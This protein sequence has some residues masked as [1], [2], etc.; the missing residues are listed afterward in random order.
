[1]PTGA[2]T[3]GSGRHP[4]VAVLTLRNETKRN[5]VTERMARE[6]GAHAIA[7]NGDREI[8][9]VVVR[10]EG[11]L[12]FSA[13][14]D[15]RRVS[16]VTDPWMQ[17]N[18]ADRGLDY[19]GAL[20]DVRK[21]LV[22]AIDGFALG[23]GLELALACDTRIASPHA[24]FAASEIDWGWHSGSGVTQ[25]LPRIVGPGMAARMVLTG[26]RIEAEEAYRIRLIDE[27]APRDALDDRA[28]E[29]AGLIAERAPIA[30][31][32]AKHLL[33]LAQ[34]LGLAEGIAVENDLA[35]YCM[36]TDDSREAAEARRENRDPDFR[37][38]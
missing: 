32:S 17:R 11:R 36:T 30:V 24:T 8:R 20:L 31:Q 14:S 26:M 34:S 10:G 27:I 16:S 38:E 37:E 21:P 23:G 2:I 33:R 6:L 22:A 1:M 29:L 13:G 4:H 28:H 18:R 15:L 19:I 7:I 25:M 5:A 12:A 3:L 35:A 9:A